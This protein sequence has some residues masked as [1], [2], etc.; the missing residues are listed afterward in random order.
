M[1]AA[2]PLTIS[3]PRNDTAEDGVTNG[4]TS[5]DEAVDPGQAEGVG[6]LHGL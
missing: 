6:K 5:L 3:P 2:L 4:I 1:L